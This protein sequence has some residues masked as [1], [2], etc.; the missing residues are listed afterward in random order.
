MAIQSALSI[1]HDLTVAHP[2]SLTFSICCAKLLL[3]VGFFD[4]AEKEFLRALRIANP[5]DPRDHD[6]PLGYTK[7]VKYTDRVLLAKQ[8]IRCALSSIV[9][10]VHHQFDILDEDSKSHFLSVRVDKILENHENDLVNEAVDHFRAHLPWVLW[11]CPL[12]NNVCQ[13]FIATAPE[14][15]LWHVC[16]HANADDNE[17]LYHM[18]LDTLMECT[19]VPN[20]GPHCGLYLTKDDEGQELLCVKKLEYLFKGIADVVM[21]D[22]METTS[23][24]AALATFLDHLSTVD[25]EN[26]NAVNILENLWLRLLKSCAIDKRE[27]LKRLIA[28]IKWEDLKGMIEKQIAQIETPSSDVTMESEMLKD[29][30]TP[31]AKD[32]GKTTRASSCHDAFMYGHRALRRRLSVINALS[33]SAKMVQKEEE[34]DVYDNKMLHMKYVKDL[35]HVLPQLVLCVRVLLRKSQQ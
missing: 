21:G 1:V 29:E 6:I 23:P 13:F 35:P 3:T 14:N 22:K 15:F 7:G 26:A 18:T 32:L 31:E 12:K 8:E 27:A 10:M 9:D 28:T 24:D 34:F 11:R 4:A 25:V 20:D 17:L 16:Q 19:S 5:D 33:S 2:S 30:S